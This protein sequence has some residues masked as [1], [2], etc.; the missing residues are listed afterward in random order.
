MMSQSIHDTKMSTAQFRDVARMQPAVADDGLLLS[1]DNNRRIRCRHAKQLLES[2]S[3][4]S[5]RS[6]PIPTVPTRVSFNTCA[7]IPELS[8]NP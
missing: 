7:A 2:P 1:S 4:A 6:M 8:V 5:I 3:F